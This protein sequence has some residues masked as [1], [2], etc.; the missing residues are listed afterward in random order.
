MACAAG[1]QESQQRDWQWRFDLAP[2]HQGRAAL[3]GGGDYAVDSLLLRFRGTRPVNRRL[4]TGFSVN[5]DYAAYDFSSAEGLGGSAP[6]GDTERVTFGVPILYRLDGGWGFFATPSITSARERDAG[7]SES[8]VVGSVIGA[9]KRINARLSLGVGAGVFTGLE[10]IRVFLFP[11]VTW[12]INDRLTLTNP[13]RAGPAGPA[14]LELRW[15]FAPQWQFAGGVAR[16]SWRFRLDDAGIA[17]G[18]VGQDSALLSF[19]RVTR[20]W[21]QGLRL[22]LYVGAALDGELELENQNGKAIAREDYDTA[23]LA[24]IALRVPF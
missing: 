14:G 18:G 12:Q 15:E 13:F 10:E 5:L 11:S 6:W 19:L 21:E 1:A 24:A 23:P 17:P 8:W 16:R 2:V 4:I 7:L 9:A 22:D 20:E 3:E